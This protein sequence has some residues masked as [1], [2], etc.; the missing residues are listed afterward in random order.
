VATHLD[1][2]YACGR[3]LSRTGASAV[4]KTARP[5]LF[6]RVTT[7]T[8][9][10]KACKCGGFPSQIGR[11]SKAFIRICGF[12]QNECAPEGLSPPAKPAFLRAFLRQ[13]GCRLRA[14]SL[15]IVTK[16]LFFRGQEGETR[17]PLEIFNV[18][19]LKLTCKC[20]ATGKTDFR[21]A[22]GT[23]VPYPYRLKKWQRC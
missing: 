6:Y 14:S 4:K 18:T 21:Q 20:L 23:F 9:H 16:V 11:S 8:L 1:E 15:R 2:P 19:N 10:V 17:E 3:A 5:S 13:P 12:F 7:P 22:S